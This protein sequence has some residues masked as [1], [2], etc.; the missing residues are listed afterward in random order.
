MENN[1]W[2]CPKCGKINTNK[3]C[4][5]CGMKKPEKNINLNPPIAV[6]NQPILNVPPNMPQNSKPKSK[7]KLRYIL[8]IIIVVLIGVL[9]GMYFVNSNKAAENTTDT[10]TVEQAAT[11]M[12]ET[13]TEE[14]KQEKTK[15]ADDGKN[16]ESAAEQKTANLDYLKEK[17]VPNAEKQKNK[18][19]SDAGVRF[20][21][22]HKSITEHNLR[23]AYDYLSKDFQN[24]MTYEGW[25]PGFDKTLSS[26][27]S[28]LQ[29]ISAE[30]NRVE[31]S[32]D[33]EARDK[34]NNKV[35]VQS[36]KGKTILIKE[37]G[38][39]KIDSIVA[40]KTGE[41]FE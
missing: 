4:G 7:N 41:H 34:D 3:F 26:N 37:N 11:D 39:W 12:E 2:K 38:N 8:I 21:E 15:S 1:E 13:K 6:K 28:N 17:V 20:F 32:Y 19:V 29:L 25:A 16:K 22:Y 23:R 31:F 10:A 18:D 5:A 33:L 24:R 14:T 27:P 36:F 30:T 40:D 35:K 9:A